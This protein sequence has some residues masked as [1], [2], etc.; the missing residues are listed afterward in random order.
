MKQLSGADSMFLQ[1]ENG[2]NF[3]H[4]ASLAIYDPSTAPG[5]GVRFKDILKFFTSRLGDFPQF[6]RRLVNVPLSVDRPYWIEDPSFDVEFHVRH[7]ALPH[8]GDWRQLC[9]Q[10]ARIHSRPLD[11]SKPLWEAYVIEGLHN[12]PG[13]P[14]GSFAL[15]TKMHHAIID[16]ESGTELLKAMH[17]IVPEPVDFDAL[18]EQQTFHADREPTTIELYSRAIMHNVERVPG[19]AKFTLGTARRLAGLGADAVTKLAGEGFGLSKL[20]S[21]LSGDL[22]S[23]MSIMPPQTRF[24]GDVSKHRV[25]EAV[26]LPLAEFKEIRKHVPDVTINDMFLCIVGGT[27]RKYLASKREL[28]DASMAAMVP[29]TLRGAEKGGDVGNQVGFTVM[30]VHTDVEDPVERLLAIRDGAQ[31]SKRVTDAIGKELARDLLEFVP[32]LVSQTLTRYV[33]PPRIGLIVSNVRGPDVPLYMAGARLVNYAPISIATDGMGLNVT[34]FSYAGTMWI[35]SVSCRDMLPDPAF[36]TTCMREA[37]EDLKKAAARV[38][39]AEHEKPV[40]HLPGPKA[41]PTATKKKRARKTAP[42]AK[43]AQRKAA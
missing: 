1:F 40:L 29:M 15:Y 18:G 31:T 9:I 34:G 36:F 8:P 26:G 27:L 38:T 14:K 37:F 35:C 23:L 21:L 30:S 6:R 12:I 43:R 10:V 25:F 4:V 5:G 3:M 2:N 39:T 13:V 11:R 20:R 28:P 24:S 7:I 41:R 33:K 19:L 17:S 16:G 42:R 22:G 32:N